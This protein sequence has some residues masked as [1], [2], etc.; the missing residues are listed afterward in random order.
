MM[1]LVASLVDSCLCV[2]LRYCNSWCLSRFFD[3]TKN[4]WS[5]RASFVKCPGKYD[6]LK[7]D[8]KPR[9]RRT[10]NWWTD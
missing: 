8:Y 10:S 7:I 5:D 4:Q 9:V 1:N 2:E 6:L 3:K